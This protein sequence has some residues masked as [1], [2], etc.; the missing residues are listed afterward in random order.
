MAAGMTGMFGQETIEF[1]RDLRDNNDSAWFEAQRKRYDTHVKAA[2]RDFV[3]ALRGL[4]ADRYGVEI[5][6]KLFRINRDLRFSA[7]K[8]PYNT[9][10]QM[11][12]FDPA[13]EAGWMVGLEP[14]RLVLG[15][16]TFAFEP[17]RLTSGANA[18]RGRQGGTCS[19]YSAG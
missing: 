17:D 1:L 7:D 14:D 6:T 12:F 4:L 5:G 19:R 11:S 2:S 15:Y 10:I 13:A 8:T 3:E 9:H 18:S 16:G